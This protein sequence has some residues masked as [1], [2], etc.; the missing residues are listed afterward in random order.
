MPVYR[1]V[2]SADSPRE[3]TGFEIPVPR[4][5]RWSRRSP[6]SAIRAGETWE[7]VST[8]CRREVDSPTAYAARR[9]SGDAG[10]D[11]KAGSLIELE[12][13]SLDVTELNRATPPSQ[14]V[15][16]SYSGRRC[17]FSPALTPAPAQT[18]RLGFPDR[19][20]GFLRC[21]EHVP[22]P[23]QT[24]PKSA[25]TSNF[26]RSERRVDRTSHALIG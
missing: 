6:R 11:G 23:S 2:G 7:L 24:L 22:S 18:A 9:G 26:S 17:N 20:S 19:P 14:S 21:P 13:L 25:G 8:R 5:P 12:R 3:G 1:P 16:Y 15:M 10:R 4:Y